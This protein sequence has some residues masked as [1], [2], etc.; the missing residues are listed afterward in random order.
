R[1]SDMLSLQSATRCD[2]LD[3]TLAKPLPGFERFTQPPPN[4]RERQSA[5]PLCTSASQ[6]SQVA[7]HPP[8]RVQWH[9][10][11]RVLFLNTR[12][13]I[14]ADVAVHLQLISTLD[15]ARCAVTVA[16]TPHA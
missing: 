13:A 4:R 2:C 12:S 5:L 15:R 6:R 8:R 9:R 11:T 14:G 16:T 10:M 1:S 7:L 3:N